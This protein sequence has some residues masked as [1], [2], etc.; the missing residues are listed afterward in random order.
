MNLKIKILVSILFLLTIATGSNIYY[1]TRTF[2][3]D[4]KAYLFDSLMSKSHIAS[5]RVN[6]E[7][8][9][10]ENFNYETID[11]NTNSIPLNYIATLELNSDLTISDTL[12]SN[13]TSPYFREEILSLVKEN[14]GNTLSLFNTNN[15]PELNLVKLN[16]D[17]LWLKLDKKQNR[18]RLHIFTN[19]KINNLI[20]SD[21]QSTMQLSWLGKNKALSIDIGKQIV[22]EEL[23]TELI[24]SKLHNLTRE[25]SNKSKDYL[26]SATKSKTLPFLIFLGIEKEKAFQVTNALAIK[27]ILFSLFLFGIFAILGLALSSQLT[28]PILE[29]TEAAKNVALGNYEYRESI[30]TKDELKLLG[31][32]FEKMCHE[33]KDLLGEKEEMISELALANEKLDEYNKNLEQ[34]VQDRTR[35][36]NEANNFMSAMINSLDQGLVV[37]DSEL[38]IKPIYTKA[39]EKLFQVNPKDKYYNELLQKSDEETETLKQWAQITF[40]GVIPFD[41]AIGLAPD[42]LAFGGNIEDPNYQYLTLSYYPMNNLEDPEKIENIVAVAT[43]KTATVL[44]EYHFKKQEAYVEMVLKILKNKTGFSNFIDEVNK[45]F[46]NFKNCYDEDENKINC[47]LA[48]MLFHTLN[49]G[50]GL[51]RLFE[52]REEARNNEQFIIDN[53]NNL[54]SDTATAQFAQQLND[55]VKK[56]NQNFNKKLIELDHSLGSTFSARKS[57]V[58]IE[59]IQIQQFYQ[60]LLVFKDELQSRAELKNA[61]NNQ[62]NEFED[63]FIKKSL[64]SFLAPYEELCQTVAQK[65]DKKIST[66]QIINGEYKLHPE[67]FQEFFNVLIHLFRNC[68]DHGIERPND[69]IAKGKKE[70]GQIGVS[71]QE[72][73]IDGRDQNKIIITVEDDGNGIN[74]DRVRQKVRELNPSINVDA[75]SDQEVIYHIFD[76]F[77]STKDEITELSGRGVGMSAIK[78]VVDRLDGSIEIESHVNKGTKFVFSFPA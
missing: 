64:N 42:H 59:E 78:E 76:P 55:R 26:I 58:E 27:T 37:F 44:S 25:V 8:Q 6:E 43:D 49:G 66:L 70:F 15:L 10:M 45:V 62:I 34:M 75:E 46:E 73:N 5:E 17:I 21:T 51:F 11:Q 35:E 72:I 47:E 2:V 30:N 56:L 61:L 50:F 28:T 22:P 69:R 39:S 29:L 41:S 18:L 1:S 60:N 67:K 23:K 53:K 74:S 36:L 31:T 20:F 71:L 65:L 19:D 63:I 13:K 57:S 40:N 38:K 14:I 52:L 77:F 32:S 48:M 9:G 54:N 12:Y 24:K 7:I 33:I 4:K 16:D 68:L 3:D